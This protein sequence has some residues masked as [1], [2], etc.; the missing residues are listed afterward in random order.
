[1]NLA[2]LDQ[3]TDA[4]LA[5]VRSGIFVSDLHL[6][7]PRSV[8]SAAEQAIF[9]PGDATRCI[10]LGGDIFDFRWSTQ[11]SHQ[12]TLDA[13]RRWLISLVETTESSPVVYLPGNHDCHPEFLEVL[14]Q[15]ARTHELFSWSPHHLIL[16]DCLFLH[17]DV[18]DA[19]GIDALPV[20]RRK[21]HHE[22]P[23]SPLAHRCYDAAVEMRIHKMVP[24]IRHQPQRSCT[25]LLKIIPQIEETSS[26]IRRVYFGHTHVPIDGLE[27]NDIQ[28]FNPGASLRHMTPCTHRFT[29]DGLHGPR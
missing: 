20:Y 28:F 13:T 21:F 3:P 5:D 25:Q 8:A 1:M 23:Q 16:G 22:S 27:V 18:L 12:D 4:C 11:G 9:T 26:E 6:F 17:G 10:V 15:I 14:E 7:S 24:R 19:G 2:L 29:V